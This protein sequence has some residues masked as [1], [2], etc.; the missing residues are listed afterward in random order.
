[1][2]IYLIGSL[3]NPKVG[4]IANALRAEGYEVF[5]DWMAAGP[6]ADDYWRDYEKARGHT[7]QMALKGF[8]AHHVYEFDRKHLESA[9]IGILVLPAGRS[10]H[11]ELGWL[12]G[13]GKS[14]YILLDGDPERFDVMYLFADGVF[15][16]LEE[17]IE[18]L[19][20]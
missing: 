10:G 3:R 4:E 19:G 11:L 18:A 15:N 13:R 12:L 5:D 16:T 17:L 8:A 20:R 7:F 2:V 9:D 14:G 1:M 6:E